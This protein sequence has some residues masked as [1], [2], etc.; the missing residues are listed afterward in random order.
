MKTFQSLKTGATN[1]SNHWKLFAAAALLAALAV[2]TGCGKHE[3]A[4]PATAD[5][6]NGAVAKQLWHC[7]MHPTFIRDRAGACD[8]CGMDLV[9]L[10]KGSGTNAIPGRNVIHLSPER[11][12]Q[13]GLVTTSVAKRALSKPIRATASI[14]PDE[15]RLAQISPRIGGFVQELYVNTTGQRVKR[16]DKLFKLYSP[17]L[18]VAEREYFNSISSGDQSLSSA[19]TKRLQ[20]IGLDDEQIDTIRHQDHASDTIDLKSPVSGTVMMKEVKQGTSF[21][22]GEKLY[23]IADLSHVWLHSFIREPDIAGIETGMTATV[24][25]AAY[26]NDIFDATVTFV[27]PALDELS[28]TLEVRLETDN[29]DLKL[30]PDMWATVEIEIAHGEKLA[31]PADAVINTG[32]RFIAFV[33]K[34]DGHLEPRELKLGVR[35]DEFV[36]VK[37]GLKEGEKVVLRALF[38]VDA[39]SQLQAAVSGMAH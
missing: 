29:A 38:L 22:A 2:T 16:G 3:R 1:Y 24:T 11:R 27:Y 4:G 9:K 17:E 15:T 35:T 8:I 30:K 12:Q 23:E 31:V 32:K 36:E 33:D 39:E 20:L 19:A 34:G 21:M 28:R 5:G 14:E 13:I 37:S 18:L 7:P 10:E 6:T 26:P 25:T